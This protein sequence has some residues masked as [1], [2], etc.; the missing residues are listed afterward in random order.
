MVRFEIL[1]P[2][3]YNDGGLI[4]PEKFLATDDELVVRFGGATNYNVTVQGSWVYQ[5]V[6]YSD[7]LRRIVV[8]TEET[9]ENREFMREFKET[10][11]DRFDQEK[12][13]ITA[14]EIEVI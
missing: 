12:I 14:Q 9:V 3:Y 13:H 11:K 4:E 1:L 10:L 8:D 5:S 2:L 7:Q 6:R